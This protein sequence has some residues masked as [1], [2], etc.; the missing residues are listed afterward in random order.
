MTA[1]RTGKESGHS[2]L[3]RGGVL[4]AVLATLHLLGGCRSRGGEP[5]AS[6]SAHS[7]IGTPTPAHPASTQPTRDGVQASPGGPAS[8]ARARFELFPTDYAG[9]KPDTL[10]GARLVAIR[11]CPPLR[12]LRDLVEPMAAD[13]D[14]VAVYVNV[15][16]VGI[17]QEEDPFGRG[18]AGAAYNPAAVEVGRPYAV[19]VVLKGRVLR[20]VHNVSPEVARG[21]GDPVGGF[22]AGLHLA[23]PRQAFTVDTLPADRAAESYAE[24]GLPLTRG[25]PRHLPADRAAESYAELRPSGPDAALRGG[26]SED[27]HR[28]GIFHRR[29]LRGS[30][31]VRSPASTLWRERVP[32]RMTKPPTRI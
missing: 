29:D 6:A 1:I 5:P 31:P 19:V 12:E 11:N 3:R 2:V 8:A 22:A 30:F 32:G 16:I 10:L 4:A 21:E 9:L 23:A 20:V 26:I 17:P 13:A 27:G 24:P 28:V 14:A 15:P 7:T 18:P 25:G